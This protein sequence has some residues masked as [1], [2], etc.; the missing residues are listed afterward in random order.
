MSDWPV[1]AV[2]PVPQAQLGASV[3]RDALDYAAPLDRGKGGRSGLSGTGGLAGY[4][5]AFP[6]QPQPVESPAVPDNLAVQVPP[7][8]QVR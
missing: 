6:E 8:D 7:A 3:F 4:G 1:A 5:Q 2:Q